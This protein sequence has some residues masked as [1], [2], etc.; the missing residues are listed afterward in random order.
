MISIVP[1]EKASVIEM[2]LD[3]TG[4]KLLIKKLQDLMAD[5][6]HLHLYATDADDGLALKSPYGESRV[7][8]QLT[9]N[10][11]PPEAWTDKSS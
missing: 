9:L 8:G 2:H 5:G 7:Y 3:H 10:L 4:V 11:L 6:D 1:N